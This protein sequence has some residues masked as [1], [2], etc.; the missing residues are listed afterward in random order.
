MPCL[1]GSYASADNSSQCTLCGVNSVDQSPPISLR[2]APS[3]CTALFDGH[4]TS[5]SGSV[6][7]NVTCNAGYFYAPG[8]P[9]AQ[10]T[11]PIQPYFCGACLA[12]SF[13]LLGQSACTPCQ[14]ATSAAASMAP[15]ACSCNPGYYRTTTA[16]PSCSPCPSNLYCAGAD[17]QPVACPNNTHFTGTGASSVDSCK[18][19]AGHFYQAGNSTSPFL[20]GNCY[21]AT[22]CPYETTAVATSCPVNTTS[23]PFSS[24]ITDCTCLPGYTSANVTNGTSPTGVPCHLCLANDYCS[25]GKATACPLNSWPASG[26]RAS[27][28]QDCTCAAGYFTPTPGKHTYQC[29]YPV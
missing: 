12:N 19:D 23:P 6:C 4:A 3:I 20:C 10:A 7:S 22:Y 11:N 17:I 28:V 29:I 13:A 27:R 5:P 14:N 16:T 2:N 1:P 18:C 15:S 21:E 24:V 9:C 26:V 8:T 25:G